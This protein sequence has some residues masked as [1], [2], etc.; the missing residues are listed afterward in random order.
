MH[1]KALFFFKSSSTFIICLKL[2][3]KAKNTSGGSPEP[4]VSGMHHV[5]QTWIV[6]KGLNTIYIFIWQSG[7]M[8]VNNLH[9]YL[10]ELK[11]CA[12][13]VKT[14]IQITQF[15]YK[16]LFNDSNFDVMK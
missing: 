9:V 10:F 3:L 5:R 16:L 8:Y 1:K 6:S 7:W 4:P 2:H 13:T 15:S 12:K 11:G 14:F